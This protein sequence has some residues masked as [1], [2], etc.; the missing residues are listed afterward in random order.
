MAKTIFNPDRHHRR[1]IRLKGC[2]YSQLGAYYI[3]LCVQDKVHL[4]G[5]VTAGQMRLN[6]AG[7]M[8]EQTWNQIPQFYAGFA[9][10]VF[11]VMPNHFHGILRIVGAGPRACPEMPCDHPN[12]LP[13][14]A[15]GLRWVISSVVLRQ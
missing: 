11:Q 3:T 5:N 2:D 15:P 6:A 9:V 12:P 4:F 7:M 1:S 14:P 10:D 8:V 13:A